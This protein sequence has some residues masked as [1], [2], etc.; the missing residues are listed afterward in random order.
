MPG[1]GGNIGAVE[2][3]SRGT[4]GAFH[5]AAACSAPRRRP[6]DHATSVH[7]DPP[8]A[9][10]SETLSELRSPSR[11]ACRFK[12][13]LWR[14]RGVEGWRRA[15]RVKAPGVCLPCH[16]FGGRFLPRDPS[17]IRPEAL[18]GARRGIVATGAP[19]TLSQEPVRPPRRRKAGRWRRAPS[20]CGSDTPRASRARPPPPLP[21][22]GRR[23][24]RCR[25]WRRCAPLPGR[26]WPP[27]C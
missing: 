17:G 22:R 11:V 7:E 24:S 16:I 13:V 27:P 9:R 2:R 10:R 25:A 8:Q 1:G 15:L 18:A 19:R 12:G 14:L 23:S 5:P 3:P 26:A 4:S 6:F 21:G 20:P